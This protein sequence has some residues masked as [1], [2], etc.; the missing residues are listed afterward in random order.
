MIRMANNRI[1][2]IPILNGGGLAGMLSMGDIVNAAL[3]QTNFQNE[4]LKRY[5]NNWPDEEEVVP[6]KH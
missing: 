2:H 6:S 3:E 4:L 5:I 1:H